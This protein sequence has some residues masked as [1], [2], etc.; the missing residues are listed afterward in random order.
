MIIVLSKHSVA[1][2]WVREELNAALIGR[3]EKKIQEAVDAA[4][5]HL[6]RSETA[7]TEA[8][9]S[10]AGFHLVMNS[11]FLYRDK[12]SIKT[13]Q[14]TKRLVTRLTVSGRRAHADTIS[15]LD[16]GS[17]TAHYKLL[18]GKEIPGL[19]P[20]RDAV[21]Q[22]LALVGDLIFVLIGRSGVC[23]LARSH[24]IVEQ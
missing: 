18:S 7:P 9:E 22:E 20:L 3:I 17:Q 8:I 4:I 21:T 11:S 10:G 1:K 6:A 15:I 13:L 14:S 19:T 24:P 5:Q 12:R 23:V 2:P 16:G